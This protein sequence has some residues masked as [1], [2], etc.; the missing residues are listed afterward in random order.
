MKTHEEIDRRS[1]ALAQ[2]VVRRIDEDPARSGLREARARCP[3]K[4]ARTFAGRFAGFN[5]TGAFNVVIQR[6]KRDR[7]NGQLAIPL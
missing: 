4:V 3:C 2:A 7:K 6:V 1:L 5:I